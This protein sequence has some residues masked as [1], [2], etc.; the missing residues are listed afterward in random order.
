VVEAAR[1]IIT[2]FFAFIPRAP[3]QSACGS[4]QPPW[5]SERILVD[6]NSTPDEVSQ[7]CVAHFA[8]AIP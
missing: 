8:V 6:R 7:C 2:T 1:L 3:T 4:G 5:S